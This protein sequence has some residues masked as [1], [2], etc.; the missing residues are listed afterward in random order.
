[1]Q[2]LVSYR[3]FNNLKKAAL[4]YI[5]SRLKDDEIK[6]LK[7]IFA[8]LD[9]NGDGSLTLEEVKSGVSKLKGASNLNFEDIFKSIDTDGS[10]VINYTEFLAA[11]IDQKTYLQEER[12]YDAF[13]LFDKDGSGKISAEEIQA[14]LH[15]DKLSSEKIKEMIKTFDTNNDGEIDYNEFI[16]M[17]SRAEL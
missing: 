14:T 9:K 5:A 12:L 3:N 7:E 2:N 6:N 8:A 16:T 10:G 13:R 17:M 1:M 11:T 4:T 15:D